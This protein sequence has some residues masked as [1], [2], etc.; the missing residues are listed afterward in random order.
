M[1][2][3]RAA[4]AVSAT[5]IRAGGTGA[6][7]RSGKSGKFLAQFGRTTMRTLCARPIS[8]TDEDFA[9]AF[10]FFT[11]KFVDWHVVKI[12]TG[13]KILKPQS[14]KWCGI[15]THISGFPQCDDYA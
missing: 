4:A 12:N 13:E 10:A 7:T 9:V 8:G 14:A 11:M 2:T 15:E 5:G 1:A 3:A 6:V